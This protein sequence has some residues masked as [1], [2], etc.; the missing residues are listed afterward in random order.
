MFRCVSGRSLPHVGQNLWFYLDSVDDVRS[1]CENL[2]P[3]GVRESIL[4]DELQKNLDAI[5]K[6]V[7]S[8][9]TR[10]VVLCV[11]YTDVIKFLILWCVR[12][13]ML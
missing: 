1:L 2:H 13:Q 11:I 3:R 9:S 5:M 10:Y 7:S 4:K 8:I 6:S 12:N